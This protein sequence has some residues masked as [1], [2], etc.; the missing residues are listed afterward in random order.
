MRQV[1]TPATSS[2]G[3]V[4]DGRVARHLHHYFT[5]LNRPV[6]T[7]SRRSAAISPV[8]ALG[9][10]TQILVLIPDAAIEPFVAAWP[11]LFGPPP[12]PL[13]RQPRHARRGVRAPADD[14][15]T[16][17]VSARDLSQHPVRARCRP[18]SISR[19]AS[20]PAESVLH[21]CRHPIARHTTRT[22]S[23]PATS[24]PCCGRSSS[25]SSKAVGNPCVRP[26]IRFSCR[27]PQ[28]DARRRPRADRPARARRRGNGRR[29]P[30]VARRRPV[31]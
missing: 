27:R 13:F 4:G 25:T 24:P 12:G 7:W 17:S 5:L 16:R 9:V 29:Q 20:G 19:A 3:I 10:L 28:P 18:D 1:P 2:L 8:E 26:R 15:R 22:A 21:H 11:G 23:W 6:R 14:V 30:R 31:P